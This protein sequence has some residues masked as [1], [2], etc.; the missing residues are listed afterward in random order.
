MVD[1]DLALSMSEDKLSDVTEIPA[2]KKI[3]LSG[4]AI[5]TIPLG[6][7]N[8]QIIEMLLNE[9][10]TKHHLDGAAAVGNPPSLLFRLPEGVPTKAF[11]PGSFDIQLLEWTGFFGA[12]LTFTPFIAW[13]HAKSPFRTLVFNNTPVFDNLKEGRFHGLFA[14]NGKIVAAFE[15][16]FAASNEMLAQYNERWN[17]VNDHKATLQNADAHY[18]DVL[19]NFFKIDR[20]KSTG[21]RLSAAWSIAYKV[22]ARNY[23][24][25]ID[26]AARTMPSP[27]FGKEDLP[28]EIASLMKLLTARPFNVRSVLDYYD[29]RI[30]NPEFL[31]GF[32]KDE[33]PRFRRMG[34]WASYHDLPAYGLHLYLHSSGVTNCGK[35][36]AWID[37]EQISV[38]HMQ[39]N[40]GELCKKAPPTYFWASLPHPDFFINWGHLIKGHDMPI[41]P[42]EEDW[43]HFELDGDINEIEA[44]ADTLLEEAVANKKWTI[45]KGA[46]VEIKY[47]PFTHLEV[48]EI[49]SEVYFVCRTGSG[50]FHINSIRPDKK[51]CT[52]RPA[53]ESA[54][55]DK[56]KGTRI[57]AGV[58]LLQAAIIRDFWVVEEREGVFA[59]REISTRKSGQSR[60]G[61]EPLIVYI[62]RIKY[63]KRP[64][65]QRCESELAHH[66]RRAHFVSA[67]KRRA[68]NPSEY[69]LILAE[70]YGFELPTGYTFVKPHERGKQ[71]REVIYRS[72]SALKSLYTV[73]S[74]DT[75]N[76]ARPLWF[77]FE[78]DVYDLMS[79]LGFRVEHISASR[80]GDKGVDVFAVK[81]EDLDQVHWVVQCKCYAP[82]HKIDPSKIRE[83]KGVL[84]DY[85]RGTRG[86][87][88]TTSSFTSG[89]EEEA[90]RADI[91]LING[92]E[93]IEMVKKVCCQTKGNIDC[94]ISVERPLDSSFSV[95]RT[96][97][98]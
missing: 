5:K 70:H 77:Q 48:T 31:R 20:L 17:A 65:L 35:A 6:G 11:T 81:G 30:G 54:S 83:M 24:E 43:E 64:D 33:S 94:S 47:G 86:M 49:G 74:D 55:I 41:T 66:E 75:H 21:D 82:K 8:P 68:Y 56:E 1:D 40:A 96:N 80:S 51:I 13:L 3:P 92:M 7:L 36:L 60:S 14:H 85:P 79:S 28:T 97:S 37:G 23:V 26:Y 32:F 61:S 87:I 73:V 46:L 9:V 25:M 89:A 84:T 19:F 38:K 59:A 57:N 27:D 69:Q 29:Q 78:R 18:W 53:F 44:S 16:N 52:F 15:F 67:H 42:E 98:F 22:T 58:K 91:R 93:F 71:K 45:P 63:L 12:S 50:S 2:I 39:L 62:P 95:T 34:K 88:V 72:R 4:P 10:R 76:K 90:K